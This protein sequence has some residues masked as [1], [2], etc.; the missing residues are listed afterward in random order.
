MEGY[1][2]KNV[3]VKEES[4]QRLSGGDNFFLHLHKFFYHLI[5]NVKI[6]F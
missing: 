1:I 6:F 4:P 3:E 5:H 2:T